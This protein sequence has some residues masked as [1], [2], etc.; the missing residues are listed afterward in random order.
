MCNNAVVS[1]RRE[2]EKLEHKYID[3]QCI[4]C[5]QSQP[6]EGL[7]YMSNGD[8]TCFVALGDC[9][10]DNVVIPDYSP[11]GEKVVQIKA[12]AFAGHPT[13]KSIQIPETV[14]VIGK[15]AFED[16]VELEKV[17]LPGNIKKIDSYTFNG[18]KKLKEITIPAGV[19]YIGEEAFADCV[20]V[21]SI[22]IPANVKK[23][24]KFAFKNFSGCDGTVTF[25]IYA[26]WKLYDDYG[27]LD[28]IVDFGNGTFTPVQYLT[29][30]FT[31]YMWKRG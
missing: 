12:Y 29:C 3:R 9:T 17:N 14:T 7:S 18:C 19:S 24:G 16:C 15:G 30:I 5:E 26:D 28:H 1:T 8:G 13:I 11:S 27:N 23:I 2:T 10:D 25:E 6:S 22:V 21:E 31:D 4:L 20:S